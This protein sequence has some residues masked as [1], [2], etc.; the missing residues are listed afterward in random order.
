LKQRGMRT[1]NNEE[2]ENKPNIG[3]SSGMVRRVDGEV[4]TTKPIDTTN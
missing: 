2:E 4:I 3:L 1:D